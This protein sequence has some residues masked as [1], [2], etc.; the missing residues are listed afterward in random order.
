M[1]L[2]RP[3]A[4]VC[5][6]RRSDIGIQIVSH[7]RILV[8]SNQEKYLCCALNATVHIRIVVIEFKRRQP[9][10]KGQLHRKM[11]TSRLCDSVMKTDK[12]PYFIGYL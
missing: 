6:P 8:V 7:A 5:C 1:I 2:E 11:K 9:R 3:T 10:F 4:H 12:R